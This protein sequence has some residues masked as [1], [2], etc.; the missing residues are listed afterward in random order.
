MIFWC[1]FKNWKDRSLLS[2]TQILKPH[3][4]I[5][6]CQYWPAEFSFK[7]MAAKFK[8]YRR[9]T[10][11]GFSVGSMS[12]PPCELILRVRPHN[13]DALLRSGPPY[14]QLPVGA[15]ACRWHH[16]YSAIG[17]LMGG[18]PRL[19]HIRIVWP[20]ANT[21]LHLS[22]NNLPNLSNPT[23]KM[24]FSCVQFINYIYT[25]LMAALEVNAITDR[26]SSSCLDEPAEVYLLF[27]TDSL[28]NIS[29]YG[30]ELCYCDRSK[31]P[32]PLPTAREENN[33]ILAASSHLSNVLFSCF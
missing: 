29:V 15:Q 26:W 30:P 4:K 8:S 19:Q 25:W 18:R 6:W 3:W 9:G 33:K 31:S 17:A 28:Y 21:N 12:I 24:Y 22:F 32:A 2:M 27:Y 13:L 7:W 11:H 23:I 1:G 14:M 20:Q 5:R 16:F 10:G